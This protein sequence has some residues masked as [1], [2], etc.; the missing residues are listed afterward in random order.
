MVLQFL[1]TSELPGK[2]NKVL[3]LELLVQWAWSGPGGSALLY[4]LGDIGV[5]GQ[6]NTL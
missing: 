4:L 1:K 6:E 5:A 2:V 3:I